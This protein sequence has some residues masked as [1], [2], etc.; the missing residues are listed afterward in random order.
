M[1]SSIKLPDSVK[2]TIYFELRSFGVEFNP[3]SLRYSSPYGVA[4]DSLL[5]MGV[6]EGTLSMRSYCYYVSKKHF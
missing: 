1:S 6:G 4:S 2:L 3:D 5:P